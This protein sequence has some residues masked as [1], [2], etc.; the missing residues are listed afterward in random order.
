MEKTE[1]EK[2]VEGYVETMFGTARGLVEN[3]HEVYPQLFL[4]AME[5]ED[6]AVLPI[7]NAAELFDSYEKKR[8]LPY[9]IKRVWEQMSATKPKLRLEAV[10]LSS[11]AWV[12]EPTSEEWK[13]MKKEGR[14]SPF[15]AKPGMAE[16]LVIQVSTSDRNLIFEW[17]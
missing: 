7:V 12:E 2:R 11:D 13:K 9:I 14:I 8:L 5:G 16:A 15:K 3:G 1:T 17:R 6:I 10:V 4:F